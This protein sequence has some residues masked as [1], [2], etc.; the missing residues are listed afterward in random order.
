MWKFGQKQQS[1]TI[2]VYIIEITYFSGPSLVIACTGLY[3]NIEEHSVQVG[4][5]GD[6]QQ[7]FVHDGLSEARPEVVNQLLEKWGARL[8]LYYSRE[9]VQ[10]VGII[11]TEKLEVEL[12]QETAS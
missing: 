10:S 2:D 7:A 8:Y 1:K 12:E 11:G 6:H 9:G 5:G 4:R 3:D